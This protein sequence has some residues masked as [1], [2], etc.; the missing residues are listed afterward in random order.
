MSSHDYL[1]GG[2][3]GTPDSPMVVPSDESAGDGENSSPPRNNN[4]NS[5]QDGDR[6]DV[7]QAASDAGADEQDAAAT[8]VQPAASTPRP[9]RP[10]VRILPTPAPAANRAI[11]RGVPILPAPAPSA[12]PTAAPPSTSSG[13]AP[14]DI[15]GFD[16]S[17]VAAGLPPGMK[18]IGN[19]VPPG[20]N[21]ALKCN[22]ETL[23]PHATDPTQITAKFRVAVPG[24]SNDFYEQTDTI[25]MQDLDAISPNDP[26]YSFVPDLTERKLKKKFRAS[27]KNA[28]NPNLWVRQGTSY[29]WVRRDPAGG[30]DHVFNL[31]PMF[32]RFDKVTHK[33][34][35]MYLNLRLLVKPDPNK[36]KWMYAYNKWIDQIRR[37]RDEKYIKVDHKDHWSVAERRALCEAI[38]AYIRTSG[39]V[40]FGSGA[41]VQIPQADMQAMADAVNKAGIH[42]RK[43]DAVRGQIFSSHTK[44][45]KAIFDLVNLAKD[46]RDRV[47]S[48]EILPRDMRYPLEAIPRHAFPKDLTPLKKRGAGGKG[49]AARKRRAD[50]MD[51]GRSDHSDA[52]ADVPLPGYMQDFLNGGPTASIPPNKKVKFATESGEE[53]PIDGQWAETDEEILS[54]GDELARNGDAS[55]SFSREHVSEED[56]SGDEED[57][58][59]ENE[60][61]NLLQE[62]LHS[63]YHRRAVPASVGI[64]IPGEEDSDDSDSDSEDDEP[65]SATASSSK[66]SKG[67]QRAQA[68]AQP[69]TPSPPQKRKRS[70]DDEDDASEGG[71]ESDMGNPQYRPIKK[72]HSK[73]GE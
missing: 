58:G 57:A 69:A 23:I 44:K 64:E 70:W 16:P 38:N 46:I 36:T 17:T 30:A 40:R 63:S 33:Y 18:S 51:D 7:E 8:N 61:A 5:P 9:R 13:P 45:N 47:A 1:D 26:K 3:D 67:G 65:A 10:A 29:T 56:F 6:G 14:A 12:N 52:P 27:K 73:P 25:P 43:A 71:D 42:Q 62:A 39:L 54:E 2:G 21:Q 68:T 66:T 48:G 50:L 20:V 35:E 22:C 4:G 11:A 31:T 24:R 59:G 60:Q 72:A 32:R 34:E 55:E 37:R 53:L 41:L 28:Q 19:V 49:A 15:P